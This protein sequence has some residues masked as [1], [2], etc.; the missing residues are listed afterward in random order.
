MIGDSLSDA[1]AKL[2]RDLNEWYPDELARL[3]EALQV[4]I[5]ALLS[6]LDGT[7]DAIDYHQNVV[8]FE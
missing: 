6:E 7:R 3:P 2:T 4:R 1:H 5:A 8:A